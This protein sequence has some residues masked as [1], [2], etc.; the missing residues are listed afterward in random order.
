M[1][2]ETENLVLD[3]EVVEKAI[4]FLITN[5]IYGQFLVPV[6]SEA[7]ENPCGMLLVTY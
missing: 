6:Q 3:K 7:P 2:F 1:A 5:P 4:L